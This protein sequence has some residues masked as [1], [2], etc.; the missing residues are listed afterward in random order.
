[1]NIQ[2]KTEKS[3]EKPLKVEDLY[4]QYNDKMVSYVTGFTGNRYLAEDLV[5]DSWIKIM[6][7]IDTYEHRGSIEGWIRR[8]M[9]NS[10]IDHFRKHPDQEKILP[11][12][13][14][15]YEFEFFGCDNNFK[16]ITDE[17]EKLSPQYKKVF[18]LILFNDY[19][20]EEVSEYLGISIG[21][22]KSNYHKAKKKLK[23]CLKSV[24]QL[25]D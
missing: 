23:K 18:Q 3:I 2:K 21:T 16:I 25:R 4:T 9:K 5:Q 19:S 20:H 1:M 8:I 10:W 13:P 17:I 7:K 6:K 12:I 15:E 24:I 22:S 11:E 14:V